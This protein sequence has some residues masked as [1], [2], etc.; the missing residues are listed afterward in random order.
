MPRYSADR[1]EELLKIDLRAID[2]LGGVSG[3]LCYDV[4]ELEKHIH[5]PGHWFG[6][7]AGDTFL[8]ENSLTPWQLTAGAGGA[9]GN[10]VQL[11]NGDEIAEPYYDSRLI[12]ITQASAT[13]DIYLI[14]F[15]TGAGG[16]QTVRTTA[17]H[18]PA[19][20]LRQ[21][22]VEIMCPRIGNTELLWARAACETD[23]ATISFIV[24]LHTYTG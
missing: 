6:Q 10:W 8:A 21:S 3:T 1:I 19:A 9:F 24:G 2:G 7:D 20:T 16:A 22:P 14:Q 5:N 4:N 13:G 23:G 11:S 15:G 17:A 18:F 12:L